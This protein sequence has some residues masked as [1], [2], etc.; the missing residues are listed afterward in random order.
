MDAAWCATQPFEKRIA[1]G[2]LVLAVAVGMLA[3]EIN[4]FAMTY[5]YDRIR[6]VKPVFIGDTITV[7][8]SIAR[9]RSHP[10]RSGHGLIDELV[11]VTNQQDTVVLVLTHVL[12]VE[13]QRSVDMIARTDREK[14]GDV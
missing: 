2:T 3:D 1:H 12:I 8:T 9:K 11:T 4:P 14:E 6:F 10:K 5:G 7:E 13:R